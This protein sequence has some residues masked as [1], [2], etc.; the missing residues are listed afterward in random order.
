MKYSFNGF[1]REDKQMLSAMIIATVLS[2][3]ASET[4]TLS[5]IA[6]RE[7][8]A[9]AAARMTE[10][11]VYTMVAFVWCDEQGRK[12]YAERRVDDPCWDAITSC[13][14]LP[15]CVS[16]QKPWARLLTDGDCADN[17]I[18]AGDCVWAS[19]IE[20]LILPCG[21]EQIDCDCIATGCWDLVFACGGIGGPDCPCGS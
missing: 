10:Y 1:L 6:L 8:E 20:E 12:R 15:I 18:P 5:S 21:S 19:E 4:V 11:C 7:S 2:T 14:A 13:P 16:G 3:P 9:M 17:E